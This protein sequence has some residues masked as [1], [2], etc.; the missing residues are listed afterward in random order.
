MTLSGHTFEVICV[1]FS[2]DGR[3]IATGGADSSVREWD[4]A[5]GTE[6]QVIST[7]ARAV[8]TSRDVS[9]SR[10]K[11][12]SVR[13][14]AKQWQPTGAPISDALALRPMDARRDSLVLPNLKNPS[15]LTKQSSCPPVRWTY[16]S[17]SWLIRVQRYVLA[18]RSLDRHG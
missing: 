12:R 11:Q 7:R 6:R 3:R 8:R 13:S 16:R 4:A 17:R 9:D 15:Q 10:P 5:T 18:V 2:P 14:A 1:A